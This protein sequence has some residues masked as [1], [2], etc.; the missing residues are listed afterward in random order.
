MFTALAALSSLVALG[1]HPQKSMSVLNPAHFSQEPAE[2]EIASRQENSVQTYQTVQRCEKDC[3]GNG[4][5]LMS[6]VP[7]CLCLYGTS[8]PQCSEWDCLNCVHGTCIEDPDELGAVLC[9]CDAGW[10]GHDCN[11]KRCPRCLNGGVCDLAAKECHCQ[12]PWLPPDCSMQDCQLCQHG[13]C[14]QQT[15]YL[16]VCRKGWAGQLCDQS[17]QGCENMCSH[18]GSCEKGVCACQEGYSGSDC[19]LNCPAVCLEH[20]TCLDGHCDC[21]E[22]YTGTWCEETACTSAEGGVECSGHG[23]CL[24][25]VC[26]CELGWAGELC[27]VKVCPNQCSG[28]GLCVDGH[29]VCQPGSDEASFLWEE[30]NHISPQHL[31]L[32]DLTY[33]QLDQALLSSLPNLTPIGL[34]CE[35]V[36]CAS[37]CGQGG[38][39]DQQSGACLCR[40]GYAG[41]RHF[42]CAYKLCDSATVCSGHGVCVGDQECVCDPGQAISSSANLQVGWTGGWIGSNCS[43]PLCPNNCS[44]DLAQGVCTARGCHCSKGFWGAD[45]FKKECPHTFV[46][47]QYLRCGGEERGSCYAGRC[48]CWPRWTGAACNVSVCPNQCSGNG[49]CQSGACVCAEDWTGEDCSQ[50]VSGKHSAHC[51][52]DCHADKR[53]GVCLHGKCLCQAE[54]FYGDDCSLQH[55]SPDCSQPGGA[56]DSSTGRCVCQPGW[57]G[58]RCET[59]HC[60]G[61]NHGAIV[62]PGDGSHPVCECTKLWTGLLCEQLKCAKDCSGHGVCADGICYCEAPY[63]GP[64]CEVA[65][66]PNGCSG[67]G[68]CI[69]KGQWSTL[70]ASFISEHTDVLKSDSNF[71]GCL[72]RYGW[73]GADCSEGICPQGCNDHGTCVEGMH[74]HPTCACRGNWTGPTC[75]DVRCERDCGQHGECVNDQCRCDLYHTGLDCLQE[76]CPSACSNHGTCSLDVPLASRGKGVPEGCM[77]DLGWTGAACASKI[78]C[79][80]DCGAQGTCSADGLSCI[81]E[82]GWRGALCEEEVCPNECSAPLRGMCVAQQSAAHNN[83][84]QGCLCVQGWGGQDCSLK[85]CFPP[86]CNKRGECVWGACKCRAGYVGDA[87]ETKVCDLDCSGHGTCLNSTCRCQQGWEGERCEQ[88]TCPDDCNIPLEHC[89]CAHDAMCWHG[90]CQCG[91]LWTGKLCKDP[92]CGPAVAGGEDNQCSGHGKCVEPTEQRS[93]ERADALLPVAHCACEAGRTGKFCQWPSRDVACPADCKHIAHGYCNHP[94]LQDDWDPDVQPGCVCEDGWRGRSCDE[95]VPC[96][97]EGCGG[98]G[99]CIITMHS[100]ATKD[101]GGL[102][103]SV[104]RSE[105]LCA[106]GWRGEHCEEELCPKQC[107][108]NGTCDQVK[109]CLCSTGSWGQGCENSCSTCQPPLVTLSECQDKWDTFCGLA[110]QPVDTPDIQETS[111]HTLTTTWQE[112]LSGNWLGNCEPLRFQLQIKTV[113]VPVQEGAAPAAEATETDWQDVESECNPRADLPP[114]LTQDKGESGL[115]SCV[116]RQ[117]AHETLYTVRVKVVCKRASTDSPWSNASAPLATL[118]RDE[119]PCGKHCALHGKCKTDDAVLGDVCVCEAGWAGREC[120]ISA[121]EAAG[122][123]PD[124]GGHGICLEGGVCRCD[125]PWTGPNCT[126]L[127][128]EKNPKL[129]VLLQA[130]GRGLDC[131]PHGSCLNMQCRCHEG[132]WGAHCEVVACPHNCSGRGDCVTPSTKQRSECSSSSASDAADHAHASLKNSSM[133]HAQAVSLPHRPCCACSEPG[134]S[135]PDCGVYDARE[136]AR[137]GLGECG[138]P[139]RGYCYKQGDSVQCK[140]L[141]NWTGATCSDLPCTM[142]CEHGECVNGGCRC[143]PGWFGTVCNLRKDCELS[144]CLLGVERGACE[145]DVSTPGRVGMW[146]CE[147]P[148]TGKACR[149]I[150]CDLDCNR[151]GTCLNWACHCETGWFGPACERKGVPCPRANWCSHRG[152]CILVGAAGDQYACWCDVGF[153]GANC[154][155]ETLPQEACQ[156]A[157]LQCGTTR[158]LEAL[159]ATC[160]QSE[161]QRRLMC[162]PGRTGPTCSDLLCSTPCNNGICVNFACRCATGWYGQFC[163]QRYKELAQERWHLCPGFSNRTSNE[164]GRPVVQVCSGHGLCVNVT[165]ANTSNTSAAVTRPRNGTVEVGGGSVVQCRCFSKRGGADCAKP[166]CAVPCAANAFCGEE[167]VCECKSGWLNFPACDIQGVAATLPNE[168]CPR[169]CSGPEQGWCVRDA[170]AAAA[171]SSQQQ[172]QQAKCVC[173]RDFRGADCSENKCREVVCPANKTCIRGQC[174]CSPL[175][176]TF[177]EHCEL[178]LCPNNCSDHGSCDHLSRVCTCQI[179][180]K[181]TDCAKR[182]TGLECLMACE[183]FA[184]K[185]YANAPKETV[186]EWTGLSKAGSLCECVKQ[187]CDYSEPG[188][189]PSTRSLLPH[190][191]GT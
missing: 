54:R 17:F 128:C 164:T 95:K 37:D 72:C 173:T 120:T 182:M 93:E 98:H 104:R 115:R 15:K 82:P 70:P 56:C 2:M 189:G 79:R 28:K 29:C 7:Q 178:G 103:Q 77:C 175:T 32:S 81:C 52:N 148:F 177:G 4:L 114:L 161:G 153:G 121:C 185:S 12:S 11:T 188:T 101:A 132:W 166:V 69:L 119:Y 176:Q 186:D 163:D 144:E 138:G 107:G 89:Q 35:S 162:P 63:T 151:H 24:Q 14:N 122:L 154:E 129:A 38:W 146:H 108:L 74:G 60:G 157:G 33:Q 66:C 44:Q 133:P 1:L 25:D 127:P 181:S 142:T 78:E 113:P 22:G 76:V 83:A 179:G 36:R 96:G 41:F 84:E 137:L 134:W 88:Q 180:W 90:R 145:L 174:V 53:R 150:R 170:A 165:G 40:A 59:P 64:N 47:A 125:E 143:R 109:G 184:L 58:E 152:H 110:A 111:A 51:P 149:D 106:S 34:A 86:D 124:C 39:C 19:S 65:K 116:V 160:V 20:G 158:E 45:C 48:A 75:S 87:C 8:G 155:L 10:T 117:L 183:T 99:E 156:Q 136:C 140:C 5:C 97:G 67:N 26:Y 61:P 100:T 3:W 27:E 167:S 172:Q 131:G 46:G 50:P 94:E 105:C 187:Y 123:R 171:S 141:G 42:D 190:D 112:E 9:Q 139:D 135:G 80:M 118:F 169:N 30:G 62:Y 18:R 71:E 130:G 91:A 102:L 16:C 159:R 23:L 147:P 13:T 85:L 6:A 31:H 57:T 73:R 168:G 49:D 92:A 68:Q 55:C 126:D 191:C 43:Q 21:H